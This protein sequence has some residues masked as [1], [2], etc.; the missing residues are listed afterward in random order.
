MRALKAL[1]RPCAC[2]C[3]SESSLLANAMSAKFFCADPYIVESP[4]L[5]VYEL[6]YEKNNNE[7]S[8]RPSVKTLISLA[9]T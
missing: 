9:I 3:S 8:S 4:V 1:A 5:L 7:V 6:P 2:A